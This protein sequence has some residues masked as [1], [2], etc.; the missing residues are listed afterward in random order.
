MNSAAG[1]SRIRVDPWFLFL[2]CLALFVGLR[3]P[4][5]G[6][7]LTNDEASNLCGI[8]AFAGQGFDYWSN[9]FWHHPPMFSTLLLLLH[10]LK[11]GFAERAEALMLL[12]S[13]LNLVLL[14][15]LT[16][17]TFGWGPAL[18]TSFC[19]AVMPVARCY[20]LWLKQDS[21]TVLFGLLAIL[22]FQKKR[23]PYCGLML[24]LAFLSKEVAMFYAAGI[25][26]LWFLQ[27]PRDR[28]VVDL[29]T[30]AII[31]IL[32]SAWWYLFFS[33]SIKYFLAFA[34][35][36][37]TRWTDVDIWAQPWSFFLEK[38]PVDLGWVGVFLCLAGLIAFE[39]EF[40]RR[41]ILNPWAE[42]TRN[43]VMPVWFLIILLTGYFL[44]SASRGKAAWFTSVLYPLL[45]VPQGL[46]VY[47]ILHWIE[48]RMRWILARLPTFAPVWPR[49]ISTAVAV[50]FILP[51]V[52]GR[53]GEDYEKYL[54][55]QYYWMWWGADCSRQAAQ[56]MNRVV[57]DGERVLITPMHYW[58]RR[59]PKP[60]PIF[61]YY[62]RPMP[63]VLCRLDIPFDALVAEIHKSQIDWVMISPV[64]GI[65]E[66]AVI[67]PMI[68]QYGLH[69]LLL[70]AACIFKT[71]RIYKA[72]K[73]T[74]SS[75]E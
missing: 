36:S 32:V 61:V 64:P 44:F 70:R 20:D 57:K 1:T 30:V 52:L 59:P 12:V 51:T 2:A 7:L 11:A 69:P 35:D 43:D 56:M 8:R 34:V 23:H 55:K 67:R 65:G 21:L 33:I 10:P 6:H 46:G 60:C 40:R 49:V 72:V 53:W 4:W 31:S 16:R 9:W 48:N 54:Q 50:A 17:S 74:I 14:F 66:E 63:V 47:A 73:P 58:S 38:L 39:F 22:A 13:A 26:I 15:V 75:H 19:Y 27:A 3:L 5:I 28:R 29:L 18:W 42:R 41:R 37:S 24:G 71:D 62:L 25:A 68:Q 45:A